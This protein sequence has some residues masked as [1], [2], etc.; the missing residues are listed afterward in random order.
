MN[1][2]LLILAVLAVF[3]ATAYAACAD[4]L[5]AALLDAEWKNAY[6]YAVTYDLT[7]LRAAKIEGTD[8]PASAGI[9]V[10][11]SRINF[12]SRS[13]TPAAAATRRECNAP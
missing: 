1:C 3:C 2:S 12:S 6:D 9:S 11:I 8:G 10:T 7:A 4:A 13:L 5:A